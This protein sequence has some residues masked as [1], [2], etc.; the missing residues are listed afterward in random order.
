VKQI[1]NKQD[2]KSRQYR[3]DKLHDRIPTPDG[4]PHRPRA[5]RT[6][7]GGGDV[8]QYTIGTEKDDPGEQRRDRLYANLYSKIAEYS[9]KVMCLYSDS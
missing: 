5:G 2:E 9:E 3:T 1:S 6:V 7:W 8:R 4:H